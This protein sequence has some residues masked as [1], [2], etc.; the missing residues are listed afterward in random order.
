[1]A[2]EL[3]A[4]E[5]EADPPALRSYLPAALIFGITAIPHGVFSEFTG[6]VAPFLL[7]RYG[8]SVEDIGWYIV[9]TYLPSCI[10][11]LY[12]SILD[13]F[14][15][16]RLWFVLLSVLSAL[17]LACGLLFPLPQR[18][19]A[20]IL[21]TMSGQWLIELITG[22]Q[23]ALISQSVA[24]ERQASA[25]AWMNAG[26]MGGGAVAGTLLLSLLVWM[27]VAGL[28]PILLL[29]IILPALPILLLPRSVQVPLYVHGHGSLTARKASPREV[30]RRVRTS[31]SWPMLLFVLSPVGSSA[32]I[33]YL[34]AL[35]QDYHATPASVAIVSGALHA[36]FTA[37]GSLL[38][39]YI[40][41]RRDAFSVFLSGGLA[42][43][44]VS[45]TMALLPLVPRVYALCAPAYYF[46]TGFCYASGLAVLF[47]LMREARSSTAVLYTFFVG[48]S[49]VAVT[50]VGFIDGRMHRL[51]G[52][53]GVL[54]S[55]CLLNL[56]GMLL[57]VFLMRRIRRARIKQ[58]D[59]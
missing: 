8:V 31:V 5:T 47:R 23:G 25:A 32:L 22:C 40:C 33:S 11:F 24:V 1:M 30:L 36:V 4:T 55:D 10:Q 35:A 13:R 14:L 59:I 7:R 37:A 41:S 48:L 26:R 38:A 52:P 27:P 39:G 45:G 16:R 21:L 6:T 20:F 56:G 51:F 19:M 2:H 50:Y 18:V 44:C 54:A 12:A 57:S 3:A 29:L 58:A 43:A 34:P 49:N 42:S 9:L 46:T 28:A 17:A 53:H 15:D